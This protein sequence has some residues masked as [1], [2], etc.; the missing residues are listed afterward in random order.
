MMGTFAPFGR[1]QWRPYRNVQGLMTES[2]TRMPG[3]GSIH[4][5]FQW[6]EGCALLRTWNMNMA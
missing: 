1:H 2:L 6:L 5:A 3:R 4:R